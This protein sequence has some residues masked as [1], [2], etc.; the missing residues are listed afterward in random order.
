MSVESIKANLKRGWL[1]ALVSI[2]IY[3][4]INMLIP[5]ILSFDIYLIFLEFAVEGSLLVIL[6][7]GLLFLLLTLFLGRVVKTLENRG[8][9]RV[10]SAIAVTVV[11]I[12]ALFLS[13]FIIL[14]LIVTSSS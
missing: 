4:G 12:L 6:I 10:A 7:V 13:S 9:G 2:V 14:G 1:Y 5:P 8:I 3:L 11:G